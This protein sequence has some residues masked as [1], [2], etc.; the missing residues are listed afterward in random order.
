MA[1]EQGRVTN[2]WSRGLVA[3]AVEIMK[4][5]TLAQVDHSGVDR[6]RNQRWN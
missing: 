3:I 2:P 5:E 4:T 1:I 6:R